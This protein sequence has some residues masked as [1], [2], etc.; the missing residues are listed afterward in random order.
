MTK[1]IA[2]GVYC[3]STTEFVS[4]WHYPS[5]QRLCMFQTAREQLGAD[6]L[7][8]CWIDDRRDTLQL[9][10]G[11]YCGDSSVCTVGPEG[12]RPCMRCPMQGH[13]DMLRSCASLSTSD[14]EYCVTG[15]E[16]GSVRVWR[17]RPDEDHSAAALFGSTVTCGEQEQPQ[18]QYLL[19]EANVASSSTSS[20][21]RRHTK[22][23]KLKFRPY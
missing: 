16:D 12:L 9:L 10:H 4:C 11:R 14:G 21:S 23:D 18:P 20:S 19:Q 13:T 2:E 8:D 7:V 3:L 22:S 6:Y 17:I 1:C 15:A 5:A